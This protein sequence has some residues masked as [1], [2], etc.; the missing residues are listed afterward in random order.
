MYNNAIW[1]YLGLL[2]MPN[3]LSYQLKVVNII[4]NISSEWLSA[5]IGLK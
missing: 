1:E 2:I 3:V 5:S 4:L